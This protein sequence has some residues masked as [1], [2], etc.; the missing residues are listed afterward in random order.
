MTAQLAARSRPTS[1]GERAAKRG[2][3]EADASGGRR[4][5]R[6]HSVM[7]NSKGSIDGQDPINFNSLNLEH[8][9]KRSRSMMEEDSTENRMY[10]RGK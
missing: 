5:K 8:S 10:D 9:K 6:R 3:D 7:K 1:D 4:S 2:R